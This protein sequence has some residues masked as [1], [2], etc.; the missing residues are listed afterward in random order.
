MNWNEQFAFAGAS[1]N[2]W[3]FD[4]YPRDGKVCARLD[5]DASTGNP[6]EH[7]TEVFNARRYIVNYVNQEQIFKHFYEEAA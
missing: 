5:Q 7:T 1:G 2:T 6:W 3:V 4:L